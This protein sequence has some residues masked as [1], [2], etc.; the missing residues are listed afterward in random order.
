MKQHI[1][2][3]SLLVLTLCGCG[4]NSDDNDSPPPPSGSTSLT[5]Q[6]H[7]LFGKWGTVVE[8]I[9]D[10]T[11]ANYGT[12]NLTVTLSD[13]RLT[14][15]NTCLVKDGQVVGPVE[16]TVA[17]NITDTTIETLEDKSS[18][19]Q[20][21]VDGKLLNCG[22]TLKKGIVPYKLENDVLKFQSPS[23]QSNDLKRI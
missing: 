15:G 5:D 23:G 6:S 16:A 13:A 20:V 11:G 12:M 17:A 7:A 14:F 8:P 21:N 10:D 1:F 19:K 9:T 18:I 22:V 2:Y 3:C 4:G